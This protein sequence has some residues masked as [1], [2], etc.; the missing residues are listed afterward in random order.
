M[1]T[2]ELYKP[3][4]FRQTHGLARPD[5][6]PVCSLQILDRGNIFDCSQIIDLIGQF[7]VMALTWSEV[8]TNC[9][10]KP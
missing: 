3:I 1:W 10:G 7:L 8:R 4:I 2:I 6:A 5:T 9:G